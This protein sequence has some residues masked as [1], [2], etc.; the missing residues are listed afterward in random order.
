M[1][2]AL[3]EGHAVA[4][5]ESTNLLKKN[6]NSNSSSSSSSSNSLFMTAREREDSPPSSYDFFFNRV[7]NPTIQRYYKFT[8]T[9]LLPIAALHKRPTL[10]STTS[11]SQSAGVT[12]LLRRSA[13]VPSHGTDS[14]GQWILVSVGGRSGWARRALPAS[15]PTTSTSNNGDAA[16]T[17]TATQQQSTFSTPRG[18]GLF[19]PVPSFVAHEAWMGNHS[20][21]CGG[22]VMLGS[23]AP[24]LFFTTIMI[25]V[26]LAIHCLHILPMLQNA[27]TE[28]TI[29]IEDGNTSR[30][31]LPHLWLLSDPIAMWTCTIVAA[32]GALVT[33]WRTAL[34]DPGIL[35]SLSAPIKAPPPLD[36]HGNVLP[37]GGALGYRYCSTCNIFR[38]PRSKHCNSCNGTY[39]RFMTKIRIRI[40]TTARIVHGMGE[41]NL[42]INI[43]FFLSLTLCSLR[44]QGTSFHLG[45]TRGNP[46]CVRAHFVCTFMSSIMQHQFNRHV[47]SSIIIVLGLGT[48]PNRNARA[49]ILF[50]PNRNVL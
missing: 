37:M 45:S 16:T 3:E 38:P 32:V 15:K 48:Y 23:D 36:E 14:T 18:V 12:G 49:F 29:N 6:A 7:E 19:H 27:T 1:A 35:P 33:L 5:T 25:I 26:G 42:L 31:L 43:Y 8:S 46:R 30:S 24:S 47:F 4:V 13:V 11:L 39:L 20:F 22:K 34:M 17:T 2:D 28:T 40:T 50:W 44:Q 9:A 10:S 21:F 41:K